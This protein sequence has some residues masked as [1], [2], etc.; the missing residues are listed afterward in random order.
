MLFFESSNSDSRPKSDE[1]GFEN[2]ITLGVIA[3][4]LVCIS[5]G[6]IRR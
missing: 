2:D 3:I 4:L 6:L 1:R 5:P